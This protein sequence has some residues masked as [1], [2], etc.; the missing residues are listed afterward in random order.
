MNAALWQQNELVAATNGTPSGDWSR[1][2]T[3]VAIDSRRVEPG[4]LFIAIAGPNND[5]HDYVAQALRAGAAGAV[6]S[7]TPPGVAADA[8]L[9]TVTDTHAALNDIA[10][11]ARVRSRAKVV[12]VTGSVGK[13]GT[14][15]ALGVALGALGETYISTGNFNNEYG[16]PLSLAGLG[17]GAAYA[18]FELGMNHAG[19]LTP[20]SQL[21]APDVAVITN[22]AA[23]HLAHFDGVA[24]IAEA[25]AEIF[26]GVGPDGVAVLNRDNAY[27]AFL[28]DAAWRAEIATVI[29]FGADPDADVRLMRTTATPAGVE[30]RVRVG[31]NDLTVRLAAHGRHWAVNAT[32]VLGV[33]QALGGD[34]ERAAAALATVQAPVGRGRLSQVALGDGRTVTVIDDAYNASPTSVRAAIAVLGDVEVKGDCRRIAVLGDMLELGDDAALLHAALA[35]D[36]VAAKVDR[37]YSAGPLMAALDDALP[38]AMRGGHTQASA[39]LPALLLPSLRDGDVVLVKGSLGSQMGLVVDA[40]AQPAAALPPAANGD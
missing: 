39:A 28:A 8:A 25:K 31:G 23:V 10:R 21:V 30:A 34:V 16:V 37:V 1:P 32:A 24:G 38:S 18:V 3:G 36:L 20:L 17:A 27:F 40:L 2:V 29:G 4:D 11:A 7:R 13:T 14:K 12:A 19:E 35:R 9:L 15:E 26:A 33:V 22:I 6:V 5:G